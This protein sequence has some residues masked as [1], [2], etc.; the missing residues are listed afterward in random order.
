[1]LEV[2]H[3]YSTIPENYFS[4]LCAEPAATVRTLETA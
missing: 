3:L 1:M 4:V 2:V